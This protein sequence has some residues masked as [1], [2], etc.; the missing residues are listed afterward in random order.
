VREEMT[1]GMQE[2]ERRCLDISKQVDAAVGVRLDT[3]RQMREQTNS[4]IT[5]LQVAET[6]PHTPCT[7]T[8]HALHTHCTCTAH[9]RMRR[10]L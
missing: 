7:C 4:T 6:P 8:A 3:E 2:A 1:G 10:V 9:A 5:R